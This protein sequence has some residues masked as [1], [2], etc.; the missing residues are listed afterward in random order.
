MIT[1]NKF[2]TISYE[3]RKTKDGDAVDATTP[4][5]P[6]KFICGQGQVME[7]FESNLLEKKQGEKYEFSVPMAQAYGERNEDM[8]VELEKDIFKDIPAEQLFV[9]NVL[10]MMDSMGQRLQGN[11]I[12]ISDE[13][14]TID[15]NH[16]F[17]GCDLFFNGEIIE[18]R[19]ATE[20]EIAAVHSHG[21]GGGCGG[22]G[23]GCG[24]AHDHGDSHGCG[25]H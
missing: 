4:D 11:I 5:N 3:M 9:G 22:C 19:D 8:V 2:V 17:A 25:C 16:P 21:C 7:F 12:E 6:L 14:L 24:D 20:E 10:P 13:M 15:F 1:R 18:V 23:G